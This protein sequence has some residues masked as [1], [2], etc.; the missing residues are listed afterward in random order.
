[1]TKG[2]MRRYALD[3]K[4]GTCTD[5]RELSDVSMEL[6]VIHHSF[7]RRTGSYRFVYACG[8]NKSAPN[9]FYNQL[10]KVDV[11]TGLS[12]EWYREGHFPGEPVFV[13]SPHAEREDDGVLLSVVLNT[14]TNTSYL[15]VLDAKNLQ[16]IAKAFVPHSILFGYHGTYLNKN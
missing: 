11:S 7:A 13:P 5:V 4:S 14:E 1:M 15:L 8:V 6:P 10:V 16:Q 3:L 2:S 12:M 9:E